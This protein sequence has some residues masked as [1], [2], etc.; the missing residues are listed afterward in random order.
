MF[1]WKYTP[2]I[3]LDSVV[4]NPDDNEGE[5]VVKIS[6]QSDTPWHAC[7]K[8]L[9]LRWYLILQGDNS[10]K[11]VERFDHMMF[12]CRFQASR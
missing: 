4:P 9:N 11:S 5:E 3:D 7:I 2:S 1:K 8:Q 12:V 6:F 10:L